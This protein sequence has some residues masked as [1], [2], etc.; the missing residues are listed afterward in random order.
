MSGKHVVAAL[1]LVLLF[2][3]ALVAYTKAA[4]E[5]LAL[6]GA[7]PVCHVAVVWEYTLVVVTAVIA[8]LVAVDAVLRLCKVSGKRISIYCCAAADRIGERA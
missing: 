5:R 2:S 1:V 7:N 6:C 4:L 8:L 3:V